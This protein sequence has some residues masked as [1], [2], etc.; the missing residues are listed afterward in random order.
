MPRGAAPGE[1]RG[2]RAKGTPNKLNR[3][4]KEMILNALDKVGGEDYLARQAE[5]N[6]P[7]F[8]TLLG[9]VLP[10]QVTGEDGAP[11]TVAQVRLVVPK[12]EE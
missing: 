10:T 9:K 12:N 5:A 1:R 11:V 2:G 6:P 7:A 4:V 3:Q 8:L